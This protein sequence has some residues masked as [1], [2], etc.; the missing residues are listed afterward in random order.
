MMRSPNQTM[1][2][3]LYRPVLI[4]NKYSSIIH[5]EFDRGSALSFRSTGTD[6]DSLFVPALFR[7][8]D[9]LTLF[10]TFL[11]LG[12]QG[13]YVR[14]LVANIFFFL[15]VG[16]FSAMFLWLRRMKI[17]RIITLSVIAGLLLS[18][19]VE[20]LQIFLPSRYSSMV[21][22]LSNTA[23]TAIGAMAGLI[24]SI[25]GMYDDKQRNVEDRS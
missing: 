4:L 7:P 12:R 19:S 13:L 16:Y 20:L 15:P 8:Y 17:V 23:G 25:K 6:R 5:Y 10:D 24:H 11:F 1:H 2:Q 14:D 3:Y 9:R 21:D 18:V 22:V